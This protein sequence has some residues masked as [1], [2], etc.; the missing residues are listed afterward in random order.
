MADA[1]LGIGD[2]LF[3]GLADI[4]PDYL[5]AYDYY[6]IA[7][8]ERLELRSAVSRLRRP[9]ASRE[10]VKADSRAGLEQK[11]FQEQGGVRAQSLFN[12]GVM[13]YCGFGVASNF[14]DAKDYFKR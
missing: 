12:M 4:P 10:E 1:F 11:T 7:S 13:S 2:V 8:M 14:S 6:R 5:L 9:K 3:D